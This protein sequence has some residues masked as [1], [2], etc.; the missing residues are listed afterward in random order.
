MVMFS[1]RNRWYERQQNNNNHI[2][3]Q[4]MLPENR[5]L[6][7]SSK[8][9]SLGSGTVWLMNAFYVKKGDV[10]VIQTMPY[11]WSFSGLDLYTDSFW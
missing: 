3:Q 4:R 11:G 8:N 2:P 9:E 6:E 5:T 7:P 10:Y 1:V